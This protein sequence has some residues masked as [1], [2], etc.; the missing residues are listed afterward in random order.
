MI[1]GCTWYFYWLVYNME[2]ETRTSAFSS[3]R[4]LDNWLHHFLTFP[5]CNLI[6]IDLGAIITGIFITTLRK[7]LSRLL[8]LAVSMGYGVVKYKFL[9]TLQLYMIV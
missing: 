7:T 5:L 3:A 9:I 6:Y 1:E 2:G 4:Y 8:I